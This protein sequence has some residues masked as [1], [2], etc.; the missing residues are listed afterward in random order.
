LP[1]TF[2]NYLVPPEILQ[3][4]PGS[5]KQNQVPRI[6]GD[7]EGF[8]FRSLALFCGL[9]LILSLAGCANLSSSGRDVVVLVTNA[10]AFT[11]VGKAPT[12]LKATVTYDHSNEGVKWSLVN[13]NVGCAPGCG[14]LVAQGSPSFSAVYTPPATAPLN[15]QAAIVAT[16]V[17]EQTQQYSFIFTIYPP[18]SI[19]INNPF[20]SILIG[21]APVT[22]NATVTNDPS[23]SGATWTLTAGGSNCSP[24][25]GTLSP[26]ASNSSVIYTPPATFPTGANVNPTI[27][28]ISAANSSTTD[29]FNFNILNN[30]TLFKGNYVFL[31]RGYY[32]FDLTAPPSSAA[33]VPMAFAGTFT[34]DGNGQITGAEFDV[35]NSGGLT[36]ITTPQTGTYTVHVGPTG[37]IEAV[38]T[39]TSF[40]FGSGANP[41]FRCI[42]SADGT[43][44]RMIELDQGAFLDSGV[45]ELQDPAVLSTKPTGNY[46]FGVDS[47]SP[48][49]GRT[50]AA[51]QLVLGAAGVTGGL[52]DQSFQA[53]LTPTFVAQPVSP[54]AQSS[55]DAVGRGTLTITV[56]GK[57]VFYAYYIVDATHFF[58]I[59]IDRGT[60]FGTVF[61][62]LARSQN[63]LTASSVNGISVIQLTGFDVYPLQTPNPIWPVVIVGLLTVSGGNSFSVQFDINDIGQFLIGE[64]AVGA[65]TFDPATGRA[66]LSSPDGFTT[67][68]LNAGAWYLYD[69]GKGFFVEEDISTSGTVGASSITNRAL[70]GTT[71]SQSGAP[72]KLSDVSGN[73]IAGFGASSTPLVPNAALGMNLVSPTAVGTGKA[74]SYTA[75]GDL[76][77]I[78]TQGGKIPD[79]SY[80]GRIAFIDST[81]LATGHG[82]ITFPA[83]LLGDFTSGTTYQATFY[84]IAPNQFVAIAGIPGSVF[85]S[86][87]PYTGVTF[88][89]P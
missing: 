7:I 71:L 30:T 23:N 17:S 16:A 18:A 38:V 43:H 28:A 24:A 6:L 3:L 77:S 36:A 49:G 15:Q 26:G 73:V 35:N 42:M 47:D 59:E 21:A 32:N 86:L 10:F 33:Q 87:P 29:S 11:Q 54:G 5:D 8:M 25:C 34:A 63:G 40:Q 55:P 84:M 48:F 14:T 60:T 68:F 1:F 56:Q 58:L 57:S 88:V 46:A 67:N 20:S 62:G 13:A 81:S 76:T 19:K 51:G 9:V 75:L 64:G 83:P 39:I 52:I 27:T 2:L 74:G 82:L 22:L 69:T 72:F 41:S 12:T 66:A 44:G 37:F 89:G 79:A 70:S 65:V 78:A 31:L 61:G 50:I 45:V 53:N 80:L 85:G 4:R